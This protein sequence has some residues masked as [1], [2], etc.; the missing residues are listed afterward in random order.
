MD[1]HTLE[2]VES[3]DSQPYGDGFEGLR[4]L[5]DASFSGCVVSGPT[6]LFML[7]GRVVGVFDGSIDDYDGASGTA[8]EAP[9]PSLPLLFTMRETGG[10]ERAKYYTNDTSIS[11]ADSTLSSAN[12]TGYVELSENVLS[13]DY[14]VV[15]HGGRSMSCAFVGNQERLLTEDEAFERAD[16]EVGIYTVWD[17]DVDIIDI[18]GGEPEPEPEPEP[19]PA[20]AA[21][22]EPE[23]EPESTVATEAEPMPAADADETGRPDEPAAEPMRGTSEPERRQPGTAGTADPTTSSETGDRLSEA[24]PAQ[25]G[26]S[27]TSE[28]A[29]RPGDHSAGRADTGRTRAGTAASA[30]PEATEPTDAPREPAEQHPPSDPATDVSQPSSEEQWEEVSA[31]VS[32]EPVEIPDDV[33]EAVEQEAES[34]SDP[35]LQEEAQ[36]R[37][38]R[39]I[40]S[41]NPDNSASSGQST[42]A[43]AKAAKSRT[44]RPARSP[45]A[46]EASERPTR[47]GGGANGR[48]PKPRRREGPGNE[49]LERDMLERED[50]IDQLQQRL[51][52]VEEVRDELAAERDRLD[53][54]NEE[55]RD[56]VSDLETQVA[57]LEAQIADLESRLAQQAGPGA[58]ASLSLSPAEALAGTNLF[59]RYDSKSAATLETA[60]DGDADAA[61]V[62]GNL[63]LEHHTQFEA[64]DAAVDGVA[65]EQF[66]HGTIEYQFVEWFVRDLLYEIRETGNANAMADLYDAIPEADRAEL[67]GSVSLV[68]QQD[69]EEHRE[70]TRFD[71]VVRDRMGNPLAVANLNDSRDPA[72]EDM[73]VDLEDRASRVKETSDELSSAFL[74][75]SSFF[76]PG[77][78]ETAAEATSGSFLSRD[79]KKSYVKLSRKSGYHL[80]L[81]ESRGGEFHINVP[82]L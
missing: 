81:V 8:Y 36:W 17:V 80:C 38:T 4:A 25:R 18:P 56:T 23:P 58:S 37:E 53:E 59:V 48:Q 52:K 43:P 77:A 32:A 41:I 73:M 54:E 51:S 70:Q 79:S 6:H 14:Y 68:Y 42:S 49:P 71:V 72:T 40:P 34:D 65:F 50:K 35:V 46:S 60:R 5:A 28:K 15:Y 39:S 3:W 63:R 66:L 74:V 19:T 67:G 26:R 22:A 82:E 20:P 29:A 21:D 61:E 44:Q 57:D 62:N 75:T 12:F 2:H 10:E 1:A 33:L 76:D 11:E 16:D 64:G 55:L 13:G 31:E 69:G 30:G 24:D 9:H 27:E 47:S 45:S 78:L 7:N